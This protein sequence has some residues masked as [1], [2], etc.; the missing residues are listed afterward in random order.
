MTSE[1]KPPDTDDEE[2]SVWLKYVDRIRLA[3]LQRR[4][5]A[6]RLRYEAGEVSRPTPCQCTCGTTIEPAL[7]EHTWD[8]PWIEDSWGGNGATC[9]GCGMSFFSHM[10]RTAP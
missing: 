8:G 9:S 5:E 2:S 10:L 6:H 1:P 4:L 7:C 3:V